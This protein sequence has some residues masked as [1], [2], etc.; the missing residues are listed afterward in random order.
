MQIQDFEEGERREDNNVEEWEQT[1]DKN[2]IYCTHQI[3]YKA[4]WLIMDS[5]VWCLMVRSDASTNQWTIQIVKKI[6]DDYL[7]D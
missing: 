1:V 3:V 4:R 6:N 2:M 7:S 5:V